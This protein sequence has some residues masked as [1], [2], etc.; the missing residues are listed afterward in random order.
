MNALLS[1]VIRNNKVFYR[2]KTL[3]FFSL[4][5]VLI[6]IMLYALFLQKMQIDAIEQVTE[7]TPEMITMVKE[8]LVAGLL[9]MIA[10]TTTLAAF[11]ITIQDIEM[12]VTSDFLT[13]PISRSAIQFSYVLNAFIIGLV[14]SFIALIGC[15]IF[16]VTT[17]GKWLSIKALLKVI[18]ILLLS[19]SLASMFN[20]FLVQ[21]VRSQNAFSTLSTI[22]GTLIGF[23]CGVY[24]PLGV[25]PAFAQNIIMYFPISH[26]T[27]LLRDTIMHDSLQTVFKTIPS[28]QV[29]AYKLN[30]GVMYEINGQIISSSTSI[31]IIIATTIVLAFV[32]IGIFKRSSH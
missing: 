15:E 16:L 26:T 5:S 28:E 1:L 24:V 14:F 20:L 27:V 9:S 18:G 2:D 11:S 8:W 13:A 17:G 4:L 7:A 25:V 31:A 22:V 6:V 21:F 32:S 30:Y 19:V 12:K 10:V 23:L 3:V 29:D